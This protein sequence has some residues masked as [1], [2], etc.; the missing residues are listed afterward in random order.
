[1]IFSI[2]NM[3]IKVNK[4]I[5]K[6][7][8]SVYVCWECACVCVQAVMIVSSHGKT[9]I[10]MTLYSKHYSYT[11]CRMRQYVTFNVTYTCISI[12]SWAK[13]MVKNI[14][15]FS[16]TKIFIICLTLCLFPNSIFEIVYSVPITNVFKT[17]GAILKGYYNRRFLCIVL[18]WS[19]KFMCLKWPSSDLSISVRI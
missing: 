15:N 2:Y 14:R 5:H 6:L 13:V 17:S 12:L 4:L 19:F 10:F 16:H 8:I 3:D 18:M 1:M 7:Q 9:H 11:F